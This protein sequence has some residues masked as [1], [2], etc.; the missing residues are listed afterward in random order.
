MHENTEVFDFKKEL[1]KYHVRE[2]V[3]Q[4]L[5]FQSWKHSDNGLFLTS[6]ELFGNVIWNTRAVI[7]LFF[8][9]TSRTDKKIAE[10]MTRS[11]VFL[12][13]F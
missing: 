11:G 2:T 10:N 1:D 6:F 12:T 9:S 13:I 8:F 4:S 7:Y 3:F 5:K